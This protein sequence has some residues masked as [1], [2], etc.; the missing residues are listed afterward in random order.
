MVPISAAPPALS[1]E[2]VTLYYANDSLLDAPILI[3]HGPST[4][5]N[6]TLNSSRIQAHVFT[7]A[8]IQSYPRLTISPNSPLYAAVNHLPREKQGD[9]TCR[10]LAVSLL[11]YFVEMPEV[12]KRTLVEQ[13]SFRRPGGVAPTMF[14]EMHAGD[15]ASRMVK[16]D[17]SADAMKDVQ[18]AFVERS[19]SWV[20][21]DIIL[22]QGSIGSA[23]TMEEEEI[24]REDAADDPSILRYGT[25]ASLI[26]AF[27]MPAFLPT[28]KLR[29]AP[30]K[31]T[32]VNRSRALLKAQKE[33]IRREMCEL[34]D[35]EERYVSKMYD[36]VYS[37]AEEFRQKARSKPLG[38]TSPSEEA[39]QRLFHPSLNRILEVNTKFLDAIRAVL[40]ETENEAIQDIQAEVDPGSVGPRTGTS[41]RRRDA[42]GAVTFA[43]V[44]LDWF[45]RFT[46][47]YQEYM[48]ASTE[49]PQIL[50]DFLRNN[51][52]S[53]SQ[54]VHE[55]GEQRLRSMLIEPV[56]RLP[57]YSLSIDGIANLLPATHPALH[58]L[59]KARDI[60]TEICSLDSAASTDHSH[61]VASLK[62][63]VPSWPDSV[64]PKGRLI[65]AADFIEM[66]PPYRIEVQVGGDA[67]GVILLFKDRVVILR[68]P[69]GST[70]SARGILAEVD[71]PSAACMTG[72]A[73]LA[74]SGHQPALELIFASSYDLEH[75]RFSE[76]HNGCVTWMT[77]GQGFDREGA[78]NHSMDA[79]R[80]PDA[81][82][83]AFWLTGAYDGKSSRWIEE[84]VKARVEGR[85][86]EAEREGEQ[87]GLRS[88]QNP[89]DKLG[90][91]AAIFE[92]GVD[93]HRRKPA[94]LTLVVDNKVVNTTAVALHN[95]GVEIVALITPL[96]ED[97]YRL[98]I[99]GLYDH[100]TTDNV[101]SGEL[102][103]VLVKRSEYIA[104]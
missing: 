71:R 63:M 11:K 79:N 28:S 53:F 86:T 100:A 77:Y 99:D 64:A 30:S 89:V 78:I 27:G 49:F 69:P 59:L 3:F 90:L 60:I 10:G 40:I 61:I 47:S 5:T 46:E 1:P 8:G 50:N 73:F 43:K 45:P 94:K 75:T 26:K 87:W 80:T 66:T 102:L 41:S 38:S 39:M 17:N 33:S 15:L 57:R 103:S 7:P 74:G 93:S 101:T 14:D 31:P 82:V 85:F 2:N 36:L 23:K 29:R 96:S 37:V 70:L 21:A 51:A 52:S 34:V 83:Q 44:L 98:E 12:V 20:D 91:L 25:Y 24:V 32:A 54:R 13:A 76:S 9:E 92:N 22:P 95:S 97:I 6:T 16:V 67:A 81:G 55:T 48:R 88:V 104:G 65:T 62:R 4:T 56:Q 72:A 42:T 35:T 18:A 84:L 58:V 68:K 19:V